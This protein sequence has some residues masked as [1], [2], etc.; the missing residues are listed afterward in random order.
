MRR[1]VHKPQLPVRHRPRPGE[2]AALRHD[3]VF[4]VG[5]VADALRGRPF[6]S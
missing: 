4:A 6:A 3:L 2:L 5:V 1:H